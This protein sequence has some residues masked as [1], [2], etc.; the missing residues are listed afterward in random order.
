LGLRI[1]RASVLG[2]P[3]IG[4]FAFANNKFAVVPVGVKRS[5]KKVIE[6][7]LEVDVVEATIGGSRLIGV[8]MTG[9]DSVL[10]ISPIIHPEEL[11][12]LKSMLGGEVRFEV[13]E[14]RN[15]AVGNLVSV[16]NKGAIVSTEFSEEEAERLSKIL[17][18]KVRR[19]D[20][21]GY[22]AVGSII[23]CNDAVALTHPLMKS[24]DLDVVAQ[25]LGVSP[26]GAT[27]NEGIPLVKS[28]V[29]INNK[30]LLVGSKTTGPE[31]MNIQAVLS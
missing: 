6:E 30:G 20:F 22:R 25:A 26:A 14:T 31:L 24:E 27:V 1:D 13:L 17:G 11:D 4:I 10:I 12:D 2:S 3:H 16:N 23:A 9:N 28:G 8:F 18:L 5:V 19:A 7:T 15:T 29:L 21:L